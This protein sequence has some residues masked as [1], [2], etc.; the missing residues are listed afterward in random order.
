MD[1]RFRLKL[2]VIGA[3]GGLGIGLSYWY[4]WGCRNCAKDN[5]QLAVVGVC[6]LLGIG[7]AHFWG[8]D[9]HRAPS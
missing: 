4:G 8:P 2:W 6:V 7:M 5:S 3:L 9:H 1:W